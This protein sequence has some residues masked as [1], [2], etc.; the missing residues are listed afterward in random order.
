MSQSQGK[1]PFKPNDHSTSLGELSAAQILDILR[2]KGKEKEK[3]K[4]QKQI[5]AAIEA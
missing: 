4:I 2:E 3:E 5:D 1:V